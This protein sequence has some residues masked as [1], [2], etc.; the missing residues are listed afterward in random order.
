MGTQSIIFRNFLR[1]SRTCHTSVI[2]NVIM[3]GNHLAFQVKSRKAMSSSDGENAN[4]MDLHNSTGTLQANA[5]V[6]I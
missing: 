4:G 3:R 1:L 2:L 5:I 6:L